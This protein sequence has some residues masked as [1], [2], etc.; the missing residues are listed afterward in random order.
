M[1][2]GVPVRI[3]IPSLHVAPPSAGYHGGSDR[4][5]GR[6]MATRSMDA[7]VASP[8]HA[9]SMDAAELSSSLARLAHAGVSLI[10][11]DFD[12][13]ILAIHSFGERI[14]PA[15]VAGRDMEEDFTN[16]PFFTSLVLAAEAVGIKVAI[17]SFGKY[18]VIQAY[19]GRAFPSRCPFSR[20]SI[21]TPSC[22]GGVDGTSMRSGKNT[23]LAH[24]HD[25]LAAS[26]GMLMFFD[27][28]DVNV[29]AAKECDYVRSFHCPRG[30]DTH[31]WKQATEA[32]L[33]A[34]TG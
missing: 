12:L 33:K 19:M 16:M 18:E 13:T 23:M 20:S 15:A 27:D 28:D 30:F 32:V 10:V 17:A 8:S 26:S 9:H 3:T 2:R 22:V 5:T 31:V 25:A 6:S 11:W 21:I 29:D 34:A 24:L 4:P 14:T 7:P 1:H